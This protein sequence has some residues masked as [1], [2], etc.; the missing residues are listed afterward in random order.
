MRRRWQGVLDCAPQE[1]DDETRCTAETD[2]L[3][4]QNACQHLDIPCS[5]VDLSKQYWMDVFQPF[6]DGLSQNETPNPDV[7]CNQRI[8]VGVVVVV[9]RFFFF[10]LFPVCSLAPHFCVFSLTLF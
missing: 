7:L 1:E 2:W 5:F 3:D 4:V 6:L 10:F 8:K 9:V